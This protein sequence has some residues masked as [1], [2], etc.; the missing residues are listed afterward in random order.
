MPAGLVVREEPEPV[1]PRNYRPAAV[2]IAATGSTIQSIA[3]GLPIRTAPRRIGLA[4]RRGATRLPTA[5]RARASRSA[6]RAEAFPAI[7]PEVRRI[8]LV[9]PASATAALAPGPAIDR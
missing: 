7:A 4:E 1:V 3:V 2:A 8:G 5:S 9:V 6:G